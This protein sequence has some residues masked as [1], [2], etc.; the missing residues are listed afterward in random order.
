[1]L[2]LTRKLQEQI[3]IGD[4]ITVSILRVKG[5]SVRIGIQAP[6]DVRV[7]RQELS[8]SAAAFPTAS[9]ELAAR[10]A[11]VAT[12]PE[13]ATEFGEAGES[14]PRLPALR[15]FRRA[16]VASLAG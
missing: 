15:G 4:N 7:V 13:S 12:E 16:R 9:A 8:A 6:R 14:E 10:H 2:V 3:Q 11:V 5:N 1:M